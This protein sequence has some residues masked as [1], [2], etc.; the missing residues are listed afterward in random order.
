MLME[1][2]MTV[3]G[4]MIRHMVLACIVILMELN[5]RESG[6]KTNNMEMAWR[7]GLMEPS[8]KVIILTE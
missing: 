5:M 2:Y 4:L 3:I 6:K 7:L 8:L 1:I